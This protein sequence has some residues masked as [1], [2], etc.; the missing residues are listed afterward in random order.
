MGLLV[1]V[2]AVVLLVLW[3][4]VRE[5]S[6][7]LNQFEERFLLLTRQLAAMQ[8]KPDASR[9]RQES[10]AAA[11]PAPPAMPEPP[12]V[13][14]RPVPAMPEA[15]APAR[16]SATPES[17]F[18]PAPESPRPPSV[19]SIASSWKLPQLDWENF[20]GVK[21]FSWIAGIALLLAAVFF[22]RFSVNQGWLTP[23]VR[24]FMGILVGCGLLKVCELRVARKYPITANAM[25]ASAIAILFSTFFASHTL[26]NI[27]GALPAYVLMILTTIEAVLLSIKRNSIF[28]ALLGLVGGFATPALLLGAENNPISLFTYLLLLNAGLAWAAA[29]NQWPL[30]TSCSLVFT[31][32]YQWNW[33]L[34]SLA[35]PQMPLALA[36]FLVFPVLAFFGSS[37]S[38][39]APIRNWS[40]L[41]GHTTHISALLPLLF[42][43][44][45]AA[46]PAYGQRFWLLFGFLLLLDAGLLAIAAARGHEILHSIGGLAT[47]LTFAV[48]TASSYASH[49]WPEI[50][51]IVAVF[52]AFFLA[53]PM[54]LRRIR[55]SVGELGSK[56]AYTGALL[57]FVFPCLAFM[58]P[59]CVSPGLL[60]GTLALLIAAA[61]ASALAAE[62]GGVYYIAAAFGL[63]TAAIWSTQH[64]APQR[65]LSGLTMY[66]TMGLL[67]LG[68]PVAALRMRKRLPPGGAAAGSS[69]IYLGL[70]AYLFLI[71]IAAQ[72]ALSV[73]PWPFLGVSLLLVLAVGYAALAARKPPLHLASLAAVALLLAIWAAAAPVAPWPATAIISAVMLAAVAWIW[74]GLAA[75]AGADAAP[76]ARTAAIT[77]LLAQCASIGA[78]GQSGSP[79]MPFLL[80]AHLLLIGSL[81]TLA[82]RRGSHAFTVLAVFTTAAAVSIWALLH[83]SPQY[84]PQL[85]LF[86]APPYLVF[87]LYPILLGRRCGTSLAPYLA[88]VLAGIPFFFQA[89]HAMVQAGWESFIGIL[90]VVQAALM[91]LLLMRLLGIEPQGARSPGRLALVAGAA[92]AFVTVAVPLQLEKEWVTIGWALEGAAL[93]WLYGKIPHRG[94][95][96]AASGLFLTVF[97]RLSLNPSVMYY[98]PR[99]GMRIWNW[100]LY[101]YLATAAAMFLGSWF[102]SKTK[103]A[104]WQSGIRISRLLAGAGV[105][106]LFLL[107]NIEIADY[108]S[109]GATIAFRFT[110]TLAQDLTYT[111]GWA[112]FAVILL[113]A[114]IALRSQSARIASLALL[115]ITIL[116]CFIHD[117]AR[118]GGLYL[119]ASFVGLAL[120]LALVAVALQKFVLSARKE[121]Q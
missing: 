70:A 85:L 68:V 71:A 23:P 49:A 76:Y 118:L 103:D 39:E 3:L 83:A 54:L 119:V 102:F 37:R 15:A 25:D 35:E 106:I 52:A 4:R 78:A 53:S 107:L 17:L 19:K 82:W 65:L 10:P 56:T 74:I 27:I 116:K 91:A 57:L 84:W 98:Q 81:L 121:P 113:A 79:G 58:E 40:S 50:L 69:G 9:E 48:W 55:G 80:A 66:A 44:Y 73:P 101:A 38:Q 88:A 96:Y 97:V 110:A 36:V 77:M 51:A 45:A 62:E 16:S 41:Y 59:A 24:M 1:L 114:G 95:L 32:L 47:L 86:A 112:L 5:F 30:L 64:L 43:L 12:P 21:L 108:Y 26:W 104:L 28:I 61:A 89:R 31:A 109:T 93:A 20:V 33:V 46:V 22:L 13:A 42:A 34:K 105:L 72:P 14:P 7:R 100:Y 6:Q 87:L 117:L 120:C 115:V 90:P 94:L 63:L 11:V 111:L 8:P 18:P 29:R 67:Y 99:G 75:R 92:L 2:L 60:W